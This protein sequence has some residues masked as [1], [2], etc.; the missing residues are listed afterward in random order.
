MVVVSFA[1][2]KTMSVG[3]VI[4]DLDVASVKDDITP[5][6]AIQVRNPPIQWTPKDRRAKVQS[7]RKRRRHLVAITS[8]IHVT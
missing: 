2:R 8:S 7:A 3:I 6:F 5:V 4:L 1:S